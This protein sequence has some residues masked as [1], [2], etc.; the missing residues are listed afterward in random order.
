MRIRMLTPLVSAALTLSATACEGDRGTPDDAI[1]TTEA[2]PDGS[3]PTMQIGSEEYFQSIISQLETREI[4][5]A[6]PEEL[7]R[8]DPIFHIFPDEI[9]T[10]EQEEA[11][12]TAYG[13]A[14]LTESDSQGVC[15][16]VV[17]VDES[18]YPA[19]IEFTLTAVE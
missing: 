10:D 18:G 5:L 16:V 14:V 6:L 9:T 12:Q 2:V 13:C 17:V 1:V 19:A 11:G 15:K 3:A 4:L 8:N 7:L